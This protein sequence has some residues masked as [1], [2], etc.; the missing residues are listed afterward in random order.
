MA[1]AAAT[2]TAQLNGASGNTG[3]AMGA[4]SVGSLTANSPVACTYILQNAKHAHDRGVV[5]FNDV[6]L[7]YSAESSD[8]VGTYIS[9]EKNGLASGHRRAL[10]TRCKFTIAVPIE[11]DAANGNSST[12]ATGACRYQQQ[13]SGR[14]QQRKYSSKRSCSC[15]KQPW[16]S[17]DLRYDCIT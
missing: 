3:N 11:D 6:V 13:C 10:D 12:G 8:N 5:K 17:Q 9:A 4:T 2:L 16:S 7:L 15:T 1:I 14:Q